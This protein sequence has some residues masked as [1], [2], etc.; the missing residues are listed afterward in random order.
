MEENGKPLVKRRVQWY[1]G[2]AS[3]L[4]ECLNRRT[5]SKGQSYAMYNYV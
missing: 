3:F 5:L 2:V 1:G 4:A